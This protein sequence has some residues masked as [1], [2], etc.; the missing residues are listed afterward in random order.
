MARDQGRNMTETGGKEGRAGM[1]RSFERRMLGGWAVLPLALAAMLG[2]AACAEQAPPHT[3]SKTTVGMGVETRTERLARISGR[4]GSSSDGVDPRFAGAAVADEPAAALIARQVLEQGGNAAD[5]ATA[6]YFS[7]A[8]TY[9]GAAGLGGGGLCLVHGAG[10]KTVETISFLPSAPRGGG[11]VAIPGNVR[12]FSYLHARYGK[13]AWSAVVAPAERLAA[14][15]HPVSRASAAQFA[16]ASSIIAASPGLSAVFAPGGKLAGERDALSRI[17]L[18]PTLAQ[19]R[20]RGAAGFYSGQVAQRLVEASHG[21]DGA[22]EAGDL[23]DYR[24]FVAPARAFDARETKIWLPASEI[25]AGTFAT[26]LWQQSGSASP[27]DLALIAEET[28]K[29]FGANLPSGINH[30]TTAFAA[31]DGRGGAVACAVTMNGLFGAGHAAAGTGVHFAASP[32]SDAGFASAFLAPLIVTDY[33]GETVRLTAA[34][35]GE[36]KA[37]AAA[38]HLARNILSVEEARNALAAGPADNFSPVSGVVCPAGVSANSCAALVNPDGNGMGVA[39]I[40]TN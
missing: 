38:Q 5:A 22:L 10:E 19:I 25:G 23:R 9:P 18:V 20:N 33:S 36:P 1:G 30:G 29:R 4:D 37:A 40:N 7:L 39:G 3:D 11:A 2:L 27:S 6:I 17:D 8:V 28:A 24:P 14:T 26:A 35:G 21:A 12:G 32:A 34:G 15:S 13:A 16:A 31:I